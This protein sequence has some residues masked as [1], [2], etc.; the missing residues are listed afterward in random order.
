MLWGIEYQA[1]VL[2]LQGVPMSTKMSMNKTRRLVCKEQWLLVYQVMVFKVEPMV[3][4]VCMAK[5]WIN[6]Y[7]ARALR[8]VLEKPVITM[9]S[10]N[11]T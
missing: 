4:S 6:K 1:R 3:R 2:K 7:W 10:A 8:K 5:L 11:N 9:Q